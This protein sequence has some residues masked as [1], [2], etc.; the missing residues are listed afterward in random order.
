MILVKGFPTAAEILMSEILT[1]RIKDKNIQNDSNIK[2]F[3]QYT[4]YVLCMVG[5]YRNAWWITN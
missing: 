1:L 2:N 3:P 4:I 5:E